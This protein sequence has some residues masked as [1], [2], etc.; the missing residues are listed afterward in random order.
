MDLEKRV[1]AFYRFI[2]SNSFDG[3]IVWFENEFHVTVSKEGKIYSGGQAFKLE[4]ALN[5]CLKGLQKVGF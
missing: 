2:Y 5:E 3:G 4:E 1:M